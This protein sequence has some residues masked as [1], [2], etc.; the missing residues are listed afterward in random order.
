MKKMTKVFLAASV[1]PVVLGSASAFAKGGNGDDDFRGNRDR[2][3]RRFEQCERQDPRGMMRELNL[4]AE[5]QT[6]MRELRQAERNDMQTER[7]AHRDQMRALRQ[8]E[9]KLTMGA[10]FDEK[11]AQELAKQMVDIQAANRA[12]KMQDRQV[13]MM[14]HRYEM[15]S[16]LTPEQ[17]AKFA[18]LQEQRMDKMGDCDFQP[19]QGGDKRGSQQ[20]MGKGPRN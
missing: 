19:G 5:Q 7:Q 9:N 16:I 6:K 1:L 10:N 11:A 4:T 12:E 20:H 15:M 18:E 2:D 13:K 17:K 3:D 14:K 8:Q